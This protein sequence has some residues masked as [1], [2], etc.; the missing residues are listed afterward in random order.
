M[1]TFSVPYP[2]LR[3]CRI[4]PLETA[5]NEQRCWCLE[6]VISRIPQSNYSSH[7]FFESCSSYRRCWWWNCATFPTVPNLER[8][9]VLTCPQSR[10]HFWLM[11]SP[12][13]K[14]LNSQRYTWTICFYSIKSF[15][16][17]SCQRRIHFSILNWTQ[18]HCLIVNTLAS[19]CS[20]YVS[21]TY[22]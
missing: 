14:Q 12:Y 1:P 9:L 8:G 18:S 13:C 2:K 22:S 15:Y 21:S 7:W 3:D 17:S 6:S 10:S 20:G 19:L 5:T 4:M 16:S 11:C